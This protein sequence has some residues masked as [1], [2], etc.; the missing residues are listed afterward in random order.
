VVA[1]RRGQIDDVRETADLVRRLVIVLPIAAV[2]FIAAAVVLAPDRRRMLA[3]A[4]VGIVI[5]MVVTG[6]AL[7]I[8][9]RAITDRVEVDVRRQAVE[10]LWGR[11]FETLFQQT[12]ALAALG[13]VI[14]LGAW[15]AGPSRPAVWLRTRVKSI[16]GGGAGEPAPEPSGLGRALAEHRTGV[17]LG[18]LAVAAGVLLLLPGTSALAIVVVALLAL[19]AIIGVEI[20]AGPPRA[21]A[22]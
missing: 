22:A 6:L 21:P 3:R 16:R 2:L 4:G 12:A 14:A 10:S 13:L 17:R 1:L 11:L 5:V 19:A 20:L 7:R 15:L 8:A 9:R 18:I